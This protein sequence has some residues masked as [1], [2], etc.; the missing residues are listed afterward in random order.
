MRYSQRLLSTAKEPNIMPLP[1][2]FLAL[3]LIYC[4][5]IAVAPNAHPAVSATQPAPAN[6]EQRQSSSSTPAKNSEPR[7]PS[8]LPTWLSYWI[9]PSDED[10]EIVK[11]QG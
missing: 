6:L 1:K 11:A 7:H 3:A 4:L 2:R 5:L 8:W 9:T 10:E